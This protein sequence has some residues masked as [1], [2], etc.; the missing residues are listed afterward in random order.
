[1][2][3]LPTR[4]EKSDGRDHR[5]AICELSQKTPAEVYTDSNITVY[6]WTV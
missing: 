3:K 2:L 4:Y 1:M 5:R 6:T